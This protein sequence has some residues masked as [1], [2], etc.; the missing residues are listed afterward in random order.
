MRAASP[1]SASGQKRW[2][3]FE[4]QIA[5]TNASHL[6]LKGTIGNP[7][8]LRLA[9]GLAFSRHHGLTCFDGVLEQEKLNFVTEGEADTL[10]T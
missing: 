7:E 5:H 10:P 2:E 4:G 8:W 9:K 6:R 1:F 3:D